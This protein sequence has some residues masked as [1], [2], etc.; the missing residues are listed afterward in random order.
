MSRSTNNGPPGLM[1]AFFRW[2]C[3]PDYRED[4]EGDLME[5]FHHRQ[6]TMSQKKARCLFT[7]DILLLC[8]PS[9]IGNLDDRYLENITSMKGIQ[10][11]KLI[12]L[13][14]LIVFMIISPFIPGPSNGVVKL[15]SIAGQL[16][17]LM[18]LFLVPLGIA[19][20]AIIVRKRNGHEDNKQVHYRVAIAAIALVGFG[21]L[22][23]IVIVPNPMPKATFLFGLLLQVTGFMLAFSLVKKLEIKGESGVDDHRP[24]IFLAASAIACLTLMYIFFLFFVLFSAGSIP[25]IIGI[26][27]LPFALATIIR[28][29][30]KIKAPQE[31]R[32]SLVAVYM[33]TIP[34]IAFLTFRF[35]MQP[36]SNFSRNF[37]IQQSETL[38]ASI[39]AHKQ[40]TGQYPTSIQ[41]L[42]QHSREKIPKPFIMGIGDFRYIKINDDYSLSFSQW[43]QVG[44]LEE[45]VLYDKNDLKNNL[46][47]EYTKYDYSVDLWRIKGAFANHETRYQ[48]WRYYHCD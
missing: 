44:S 34:L 10:W 26:L 13:N 18:G 27:L 28:Q 16:V 15:F 41:Q 4:I 37:A 33:I 43:L 48:N 12:T 17:G 3:H 2:F 1:L 24:F 7:K 14:L 25:A 31:G 40:K 29:V 22:V 5:R 19:W 42:Y 11:L 38:I 32:F 35:V 8:R 30:R 45:I 21:F 6:K 47:G 23:G 46:T 9:I 39:E 36:I 20:K